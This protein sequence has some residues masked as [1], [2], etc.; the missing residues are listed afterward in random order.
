[1]YSF[2]SVMIDRFSYHGGGGLGRS[3]PPISGSEDRPAQAGCPGS[4]PGGAARLY[5]VWIEWTA[6]VMRG[7]YS[8]KI[9]RIKRRFGISGITVNWH[10]RFAVSDADLIDLKAVEHLG[11]IRILD[12]SP[13]K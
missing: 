8:G 10:S 6:R 1:M 12:L 13:S 2:I 3:M 11:Y 4:T 5:E 7:G 9:A